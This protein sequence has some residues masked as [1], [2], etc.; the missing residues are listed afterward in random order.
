M[1]GIRRTAWVMALA[2]G[3]GMGLGA[4]PSGNGGHGP[5]QGGPPSQ[6]GQGGGGGEGGGGGGGGGGQRGDH[7][8]PSSR[9][10][11][12]QLFDQADTNHD[13][14]LSREEFTHFL[15][16]HRPPP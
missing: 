6:S 1:S 14:S 16:S 8:G 10:S 2:A 9:P 12:D 3:G 11:P 13:G 5:R 4:Q 15:Q 7:R